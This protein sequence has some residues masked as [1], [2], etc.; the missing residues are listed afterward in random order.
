MKKVSIGVVLVVALLALANC[1]TSNE[2]IIPEINS[3]ANVEVDSL[4]QLRLNR[5]DSLSA[6]KKPKN[7]KKGTF[8]N[9][10]KTVKKK[11][12]VD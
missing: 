4:D 11:V 6:I 9:P 10:P 1:K 2:S 7:V 12:I 3:S 8:T 5:V